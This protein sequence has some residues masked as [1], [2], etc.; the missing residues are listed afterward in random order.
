[1]KLHQSLNILFT[2][3]I[4]F[5]CGSFS[6]A[7]TN[8]DQSLVEVRIAQDVLAPYRE[9][10][11]THGFMFGVDYEG[12]V[13]KNFFSAIDGATYSDS[14]GSDAIPFIHLSLDYKYNF[15]LGSFALGA[16]FG[17]GSIKGNADHSLDVTKYG[18]GL[19]FIAD[20]ILPE[21]YV[22]PYIGI[23]A[24]Q[25][26]TKDSNGTDSKSETTGIGYNYTVGLLLQLDWIDYETAKQ[27]TFNYGLQNTYIDVYATQYAKTGDEA[28]V[29]TE[30][31][32]LFGAGIKFEF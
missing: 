23:N 2:L 8:E 9:R 20:A 6:I 14:Y 19:K 17:S 30:T 12:L 18:A 5:V 4:T 15:S 7:A 26:A 10:R 29:N 1:M 22:A 31:D 16:D 28:D 27:A 13:L 24:W 11:G 25:M 32:F 3:L 21:P